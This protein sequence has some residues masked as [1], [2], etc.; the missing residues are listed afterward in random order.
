MASRVGRRGH[1]PEFRASVV[2][3]IIAGGKV[4]DVANLYGVSKAS[5]WLW[6]KAAG[7]GGRN[8]VA[9]PTCH[10]ERPHYGR[11]LCRKCYRAEWERNGNVQAIRRE[12]FERDGYSCVACGSG[13]ELSLDHVKHYS[14][15]G[16]D[17]VENLRAACMPCN[18]R[19]GNRW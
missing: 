7:H 15:G 3:A 9:P 1:S 18:R 19:R 5:I 2:S 14:A 10:P 11:G 8:I 4:R 17:T 6:C 16:Q 12:V 13:V